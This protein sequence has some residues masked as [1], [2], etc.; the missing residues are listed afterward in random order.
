[1]E[2]KALRSI[3]DDGTKEF[4]LVNK[5]G[6]LICKIHFRPGDWSIKDRFD[7]FMKDWDK[8]VEPLNELNIKNDGT[9]E[10]DEEW[11]AI[12]KIE[13][14]VKRRMNELFDMED[15][16][17]IFAKR[18]M[19]SAVNGVFFV[20]NVLLALMNIINETVTKEMKQTDKRMGKYLKDLNKMGKE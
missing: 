16:D 5:F 2:E 17:K 7:E 9:A 4:E 1:M 8:I 10:N 15:A 14:E 11:A 19:F 13:A 20:E 12:K 6:Q 3:I 18:N